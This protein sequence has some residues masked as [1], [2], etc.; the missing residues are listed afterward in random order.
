MVTIDGRGNGRSD[1]PA[2]PAA[3]AITEYPADA[4]AVLDAIGTERA[5][6]VGLS[7]GVARA[8]APAA[9]SPAG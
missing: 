6:L 1:R 8:L 3:Y 5:V 7:M 9:H 2:A 4:V